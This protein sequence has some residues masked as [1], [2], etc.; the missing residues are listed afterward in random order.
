[1]MKLASWNALRCEFMHYRDK[2]Q[3]EVDILIQNRSGD[4]VGIE[5]KAAAT[6]TS[7]DFSGLRKLAEANGNKM[8]LGMVLYDHDK[9]IPFGD[10]LYAVPVSAL[11]H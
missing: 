1:L 2:Q 10:K 7:K 9:V 6:V 11:W 4:M 5:V 8:V 3:N